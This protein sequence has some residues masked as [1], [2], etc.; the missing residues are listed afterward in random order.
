[1]SKSPGIIRRLSNRA[2]KIAGRRRQ[3]SITTNSRDHSSGPVTMRRRS[4]STSTAPETRGS[5]FSESDDEN[6][7][8]AREELNHTLGGDGARDVHSASASGSLAGN[9]TTDTS[10]GPVIP[11][12]LLQ[13]TCMVKV[14]KKKRKHVTF[15]LDKDAAK[16]SWD[17]Q[18]PSKSF[19][20]DDIK[21]IRTGADARNYREEFKVPAEDEPRFFSIV[22]AIPDKSKGRSQK[23]MHLIAGDDRS[24]ELWTTTLDAISKHRHELMVS[25]SSFNDKAVRACWRREMNKQFADKPHSLDEEEIDLVGVERLCR[26]LHIHGVYNHLRSKFDQADATRT[27]RLN[28]SEFQDFVRLMKRRED[29]RA[30]YREIAMASD[31]G[32]TLQEFLDFLRDVQCE[33]VESD[34]AHW[35][36]V[37]AKFVRRSKTKEQ[38]QQDII[39]GEVPLMSEAALTSFLTSTYNLPVVELPSQVSLDRPLHEYFISSSHNTYLLGRQ[40]HGQSSVEA[41]I[42]ALSRGCRCVEVDCWNGNEGPVVMHGRTLT[43]QVSF[44][45]VMSTISKYAFVKTP[46]PLVI[47]LEVHCNAKQ[48]AMMAQIIKDSCGSKLVTEPLD[49]TSSELPSPSQLLNRILV[50]VKAPRDEDE[51]VVEPPVLGRKRGT[52]FGSPSVRPV[53]LD[54]SVVPA[55]PLLQTPP[56]T[57]HQRATGI[58]GKAQMRHAV[59]GESQDSLSSSTSE[60]ES[61]ND[62][63]PRTIDDLHKK[64][65]SKIIRDLGELGVYSA[66][67][68]FHGFDT[69]E[70]K[71]YNHVFSFMEQTFARHSR[72]PEAK[73]A[74]VRH[75]MRHLMRV[76]PN[77]WRVASTNFDPLAYWR[78]GVQMAALN[79]QT[80]D[81]GMQMNEAMFSGGTDQTG[82]VLKPSGLREIR[83]LPNV[84]EEAGAGYLRRE[85]K[86][87]TFSI[88]V[89]S[90]Q[91][92]MRPRNLPPNRTVDPYIEV[93]VYHADDKT[94]N[95]K[96]LVGEG[97]LDASGRDGTSGL[98]TPHRR[99][100]QIIQ[101][102]GFNP[103]F[104]KKFNFDL[105]TKYPDLVF[106]RWT[107]R[108]SRDGHSYDDKGPPL[109]VYTAKLSSLRQ[110]YRTLPLMD[111]NGDQFLFS[112]LFCGIKI[113]PVTS[114]FVNS[115]DAAESIGKLKSIS[116]SVFARTPISPKTSVDSGHH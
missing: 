37:F 24:F 46:F 96:A 102:N 75:N 56:M 87:V 58:I 66:G 26:S 34:R 29:I 73:R 57:P 107:V 18:K 10:S 36:M 33:D 8:E 90:A 83:I 109:A 62:E 112:T 94:K 69:P 50:K 48:Q 72:T 79:W 32:I 21:E 11:S 19:Y 1:M 12:I 39:D 115:P 6:G 110:G 9:P 67:L 47:S 65:Q 111:S 52:S 93:E 45:D 42:S 81:L 5:L 88:D 70:G 113:E 15:T 17:K 106:V 53:V 43:S 97:G 74:L 108:T 38:A 78:R 25:L 44:A 82:Y 31:K 114:I 89:I 55:T 35:E 99:R 54:N 85:R 104:D 41:Y 68:K 103:V 98:G 92:L 3:S 7:D 64:K 16:V 77:A 116:R 59:S 4:D 86:N 60:S 28:F 100:T 51:S 23:I 49:P 27:G 2:S 20:I 14:S 13:G 91:Q 63:S 105:T 40:V 61:M 80:Y 101:E 84:P 95:F 71:T 22:Y 30:I 76:Y